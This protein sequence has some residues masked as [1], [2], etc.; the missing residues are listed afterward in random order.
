MARRQA[1]AASQK[2]LPPSHRIEIQLVDPIATLN[3]RPGRDKSVNRSTFE[4][5]GDIPLYRKNNKGTPILLKDLLYV[6]Q[7]VDDTYSSKQ[8]QQEFETRIP[9]AHSEASP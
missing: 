7:F 5:L 2:L 1:A 9:D 8:G 6:Q 3:F 4:L